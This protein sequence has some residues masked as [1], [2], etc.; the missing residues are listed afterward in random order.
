MANQDSRRIRVGVIGCG[1]VAQI[2]HLPTLSQ[3][4]DRFEVTALCDISRTVLDGVGDLWGVARRLTDYRELAALDDVDAV[5]I[6]NPDPF[7]ADAALAAIEH[8]K[9][10]LVEKPMCLNAREC[11]EVA[12]AADGAG[13]IVQVGY[14]R[15]HAAAM[16]EA[17]ALLAEVGDIRLARVHDLIGFN[18]IIINGTSRVIRG[19]DVPAAA[20]EDTQTRR[21]AL[22]EEALGPL[23]PELRRAYDLLLGL[24]SHDISAMRELLGLPHGVLHATARQNGDYV[25]AALD[26]GGYVCQFETGVDE[27]PRFDAH[28]EVFGARHKLR[29]Q[30]DTPYVRNL[31]ITLTVLESNGRGGTVE[32]TSLPEWGDAFV[33]EW[34]AFHEHVTERTQPAMNAADFRHDLDLFADMIELMAAADP[35][36]TG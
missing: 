24:G 5:L 21:A 33:A 1:E 25:T 27:I 28:I 8:G 34:R 14:M 20:I 23:P 16:A 32:R 19:D 2:I 6:C 15:R 3:L 12:A 9:D 29:I 36:L 31:P 17:K 22:V 10:V 7:H 18:H 26:Y 11:D 4:A 35:A 13:A 30:Y